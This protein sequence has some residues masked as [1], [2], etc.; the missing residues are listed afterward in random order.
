M[1][2]V[3]GSAPFPRL[4]GDVGGTHARFGGVASDGEGGTRIRELV[5]DEHASLEAA[6]ASYR[7]AAAVP[8]PAACAIAIATPVTGDS[9]SMTNRDWSFS[10]DALRLRL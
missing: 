5:C 7:R 10:I 4:V 9:V 8:A 2:A 1:A 3:P 6:I